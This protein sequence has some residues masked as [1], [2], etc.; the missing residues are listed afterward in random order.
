MLYCVCVCARKWVKEKE[1][2]RKKRER[3]RGE[4]EEE[5]FWFVFIW[6]A[7]KTKRESRRRE[8]KIKLSCRHRSQKNLKNSS[9]PLEKGFNRYVVHHARALHPNLATD[10]DEKTNREHFFLVRS[11]VRLKSKKLFHYV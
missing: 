5:F 4:E 1:K 11:R 7:G 2:E 8:K 6:E 9:F 3:E 10:H